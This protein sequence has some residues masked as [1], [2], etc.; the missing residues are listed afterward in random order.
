MKFTKEII[1]KIIKE[2]L[3]SDVKTQYESEQ[4]KILKAEYNIF[5]FM[6][7]KLGK[8]QKLVNINNE[9]IKIEYEI[10][11]KWEKYFY[12]ETNDYK[13]FLNLKEKF[14]KIENE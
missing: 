8:L 9:I 2:T 13:V 6:L 3:E 1:D 7:E 12:K 4:L 10:P 5:V 11:T 14:K